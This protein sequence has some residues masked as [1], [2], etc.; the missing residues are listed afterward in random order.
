MPRNRLITQSE[1]LYVGPT[2]ATGYHFLQSGVKIANSGQNSTSLVRQLF[3]VQ[4]INDSYNVGN[5]QPVSQLGELAP[6]DYVS[7]DAPT[8]QLSFS[9]LLANMINEKSMGFSLSSGSNLVGALSGILNKNEDDKNYFVLI[10]KEGDD[11]NNNTAGFTSVE[12]VKGIGNGFITNY[13]VQASV[14]SLPTVDVSVEGSNLKI[15]GANVVADIPALHPTLGTPI[16][17]VTYQIPQGY[18][19]ISGYGTNANNL[20][21]SAVRPGD[22]SLS[23]GS[24]NELGPL[25]SDLKLQ[26]F[27]LQIPL[28]RAP[29]NQLGSKFAYARELQFPLTATLSVTALVGDHKTGNLYDIFA[30][31]ERSQYDATIHMRNPC[32]TANTAG[33]ILRGGQYVDQQNTSSVGSNK[34]VTINFQFP[35]GGPSATGT[36]IF[37]SGW[38][39]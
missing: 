36:N 1:A 38:A 26:S 30:N 31:C 27:N 37:M 6:I 2:P 11:V 21:I 22:I 17:S 20:S 5:L 7:I 10:R 39:Y 32:G 16:T 35:I 19:N 3:R 25:S 28:N 29:I 14:G 15:D 34:T 33:F 12:Y 13:T 23:L 9:Y 24:Y 18:T 8:A 4:N